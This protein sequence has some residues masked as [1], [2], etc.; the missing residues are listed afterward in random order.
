MS[1]FTKK[2]PVYKD[3][4]PFY[5]YKNSCIIDIHADILKL[6]NYLYTHYSGKEQN[7]NEYNTNTKVGMSINSFMQT[8]EYENTLLREQIGLYVSYITFF[9]SSH[10]SYLTKLSLKIQNF[11]KEIEEEIM[12]NHHG[13]RGT[14][15][16]VS[17]TSLEDIQ[18]LTGS[19]ISRYLTSNEDDVPT[20]IEKLLLESENAVESGE[21]LI[22]E[23]EKRGIPS[24]EE[25]SAVAVTA[26]EIPEESDGDIVVEPENEEVVSEN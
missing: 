24:E 15:D 16:G 1:D 12:I 19:E 9:H 21:S 17:V 10:S 14:G 5:E 22:E 8:L 3:L 2:Y 11:Q 7:I 18:E 13:V 20:E 6:V 23:F 4:E 25:S 26:D